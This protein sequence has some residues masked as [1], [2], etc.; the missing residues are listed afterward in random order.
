MSRG[1]LAQQR[2]I[3][4]IVVKEELQKHLKPKAY[5]ESPRMRLAA[6]E[7]EAAEEQG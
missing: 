3:A 4:E 2:L 1:G 7:A 5:W 6:R